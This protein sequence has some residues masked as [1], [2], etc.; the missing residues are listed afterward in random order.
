MP[1]IRAG[2]KIMMVRWGRWGTVRLLH[3]ADGASVRQAINEGA[4]GLDDVVVLA[5]RRNRGLP[6][7]ELT[8]GRDGSFESREDNRK[9]V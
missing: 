6:L 8:G 4:A 7:V 2:Q 9:R 5:Q 3:S 1:I